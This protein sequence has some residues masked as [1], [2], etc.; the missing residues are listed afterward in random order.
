MCIADAVKTWHN[1]GRNMLPMATRVGG[2]PEV[3][4]HEKSGFL[5]NVGDVETMA[6]YATDILADESKLRKMARDCRA[7]AKA[8]FCTSKII[9]QYEDYYRLVLERSS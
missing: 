5:A 4:E 2:I 6:G 1:D 3:I 9:P 7:A 8:R